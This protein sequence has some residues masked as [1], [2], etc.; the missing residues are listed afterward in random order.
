ME[1]KPVKMYLRGTDAL[2]FVKYFNKLQDKYT[3]T[4]VLATKT[5]YEYI[6]S[7][8]SSLDE[9]KYD[10][11]PIRDDPGSF[12][13]TTIIIPFTQ[14]F[15]DS[16][17][18]NA[19]TSVLHEGNIIQIGK[20]ALPVQQRSLCWNQTLPGG[21]ELLK[22][23]CPCVLITSVTPLSDS[24]E[25]LFASVSALRKVGKK[26][27]GISSN[28]N[29]CLLDGMYYFPKAFLSENDDANYSL[30]KFNSFV[31]KI[32]K[33]E[34]PDIILLESPGVIMKSSLTGNHYFG[35]ETYAI[36]Q[37]IVPDYTIC[38]APMHLN[39]LEYWRRFNGVSKYKFGFN[40]DAVQV[41]NFI[42][43]PRYNLDSIDRYLRTAQYTSDI[44]SL[45]TEGEVLFFD[46]QSRKNFSEL[47]SE[48]NSLIERE[49]SGRIIL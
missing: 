21:D 11:E 6:K 4:S 10:L 46:V 23:D 35:I 15:T 28:P 22:L 42:V 2:A 40:I 47:V 44:E 5:V 8:N 49:V 32:Q 17:Q 24:L 48:L 31:K 33:E 16:V 39:D 18:S 9:W 12:R 20:R 43:N 45:L 30:A 19:S 38:C 1:P 14:H 7:T 3:V 13:D 26:A 29:V 36:S 27:I 41:S 34:Y 25:V 37:A